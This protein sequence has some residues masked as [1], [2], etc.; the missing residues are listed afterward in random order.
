[1]WKALDATFRSGIL[2]SGAWKIRWGLRNVT[3]RSEAGCLGTGEGEQWA[4]PEPG[5]RQ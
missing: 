2:W 3:G 4:G 1:V 5:Q